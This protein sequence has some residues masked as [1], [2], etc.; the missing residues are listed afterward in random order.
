[1]I[2]HLRAHMAHSNLAKMITLIQFVLGGG[3]GIQLM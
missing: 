1:M 2:A 3:G